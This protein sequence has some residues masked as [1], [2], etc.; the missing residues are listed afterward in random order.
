MTF[1]KTCKGGKRL[2]IQISRKAFPGR[3]N[4]TSKGPTVGVHLACSKRT[5][6]PSD[7][8]GKRDQAE[9]EIKEA[10]GMEGWPDLVGSLYKLAF[11]LTEKWSWQRVLSKG[12]TLSDIY[13]KDDSE[14]YIKTNLWGIMCRRK[15]TS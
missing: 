5:R 13:E 4:K 1:D 3:E 12:V 10:M 8:N 15:E 7:W 14:C 11:T 6:R 2:A 9:D